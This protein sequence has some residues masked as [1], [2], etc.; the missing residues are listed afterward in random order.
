MA[1]QVAVIRNGEVQQIGTPEDIYYAPTTAF[2]ANFVGHADFIPGIVA[3]PQ[4][5]TEIGI[6][7][8]PPDV[9]AGPVQVMIRHE[10][11]NAK[12]GG[13]LATVEE[14]EF[15]GGEILYRL[16]SLG[17]NHSLRERRPVELAVGHQVPVEAPL[18]MWSSF[19]ALLNDNPIGFIQPKSGWS[20]EELNTTQKGS[21]LG[22]SFFQVFIDVLLRWPHVSYSSSRSMT[23]SG[24]TLKR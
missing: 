8:C 3:G 1:D 4:I 12:S 18:L 21:D 17:I 20:T 15:L 13:I 7:A 11:V 24:S 22:P 9:P 23:P 14:R 16:A 5:Q 10:A 2:V 19:P 6:F